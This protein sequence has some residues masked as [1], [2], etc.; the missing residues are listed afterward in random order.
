MVLVV[1]AVLVFVMWRVKKHVKK[2]KSQKQP[3][4][5]P[6]KRKKSFKV[7]DVSFLDW[8]S[9]LTVKKAKKAVSRTAKKGGRQVAQP[10]NKV[11]V[12]RK[13]K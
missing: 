3:V 5:A 7:G 10:R 13:K 2:A 12:R 9:P 11:Q 8:D 1:I 4:Q 6:V